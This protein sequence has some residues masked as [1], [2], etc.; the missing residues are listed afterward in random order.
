MADDHRAAHRDPMRRPD[1]HDIAAIA[2]HD[3]LTTPRAARRTRRSTA[4]LRWSTSCIAVAGLFALLAASPSRV[5]DAA[6][7]AVAK[8]P[9]IRQFSP[10]GEVQNVRQARATFSVPMVDFGDP[11]AA[12]PFD[13]RC[14]AAGTG[15]WVNDRTWVYDFTADVGPGTRCNFDLKADAKSRDGATVTGKTSF[16]F[17]T[18]GPAI[19]RN[20]PSAGEGGA[21][22]DEEQVFVLVLNGPA[23]PASVTANAWCEIQGVGER[24]GVR[25]VD[26]DD[27]RQLLKRFS[28][29]SRADNVTMLACTRRLPNGAKVNLVWGK[30]IAA[31]S[32]IATTVERRLAFEVRPD[33]TASFTCERENA[34]AACTPVRPVKL[35]FTSPVPR[36]IAERFV[37]RFTDNGKTIEKRPTF[38]PDDRAASTSTI[39]FRPPFAE[40]AEITIDAPKDLTDDSGR[41]LSNASLFPLKS[42]TALAP[43]LAKFASSP[44]GILEL[45]ADPVLPLTVR[46]VEAALTIRGVDVPGAAPAATNASQGTVRTVDVDGDQGD[47]T[48]IEWQR[49]VKRYHESSIDRDK[50]DP[51]DLPPDIRAIVERERV[52]RHKRNERQ[53]AKADAEEDHTVRT[54]ELSLLKRDPNAKPLALPG[55]R[56]DDPRPFEVVGIPLPQPGFHIVEIES[57]RLGAALLGKPAPMFVRTTALVTN[58]GVHVKFGTVNAGVWVTSLDRAKPVAG[59]V[60]QISDCFGKSLWT[61]TSD[62][63]GFAFVPRAFPKLDYGACSR[64]SDDNDGGEGPALLGY[65]VSARKPIVDGPNAGRTDMAFVWSSWNEGIESWRFN[66]RGAVGDADEEDDAGGV[67]STRTIA[68][69]V[70]D[71]TLLRAGQTVSMKH[72]MRR[73]TLT[74][75]ALPNA[76]DLPTEVVITH[77]GSDQEFP[78]DLTWRAGR[79]AET[80][81]SC[82]TTRSSGSIRSR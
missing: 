52:G 74:S 39:E 57:Q 68:H 29:E 1:P 78:F 44:F 11:K 6:P 67:A 34:Q 33:F 46:H 17:S 47:A 54:R 22:I 30:G 48:L 60:V 73:E 35:E 65:F 37:V 63:R 56:P 19:V 21:G 59:A 61:G 72:F 10:Q 75:L 25:I 53:Q 27:R 4:V 64:G 66:L 81:S 69:T 7:A 9:I 12:T 43:P 3:R 20:F 18:G 77:V 28:L 70:F 62:A 24:V 55:A 15:R 80:R 40:S 79:Y 32:G 13:V 41:P 82:P 5:A 51:A 42:K 58:L 26:G 38:E 50:V 45:N 8:T 76:A 36:P 31:A 14:P 71:R 49:R 23:T 2:A 16:V